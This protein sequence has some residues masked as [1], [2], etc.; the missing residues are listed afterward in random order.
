MA[1]IVITGGNGFL[2]RHIAELASAQG[3]KAIS[4]SRSGKP[5]DLGN[6]YGN[7]TWVAADV[8]DA[9]TWKEH[10]QDCMA[11]VHS[12]GTY[13]EDASKGITHERMNFESSRIA[14]EA[15][16]QAGVPKMVYISA[17]GGGPDAADSYTDSKRRA[18]KVLSAM[19]FSLA[20]LRPSLMYGEENPESIEW[21]NSMM[22]EMEDPAKRE[23]MYPSRPLPV[24]MVAAVA[25]QAAID[26]Q[27]TGVLNVDDIDRLANS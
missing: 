25:V 11:M 21:R 4:I 26:E 14:G 12:I 19:N 6:G 5:K 1:H 20:I 10:L 2:G 9:S 17:A 8:F 24:A 16:Q 27:L 22:K 13:M 3:I 18:E 15:A 7:V 23:K